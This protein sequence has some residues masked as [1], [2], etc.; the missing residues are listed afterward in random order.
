MATISKPTKEQWDDVK[1][2]LRLPYSNVYFLIDGYKVAASV[3][4]HKMRLV[5]T[6]YV[7]GY[8]RGNDLWHG[9]EN[10]I[11]QMPEIARRFY[12]LRRKAM[13]SAKQVRADERI[14]GKRDCKKR[15]IYDKYLFVSPHFSTAGAFIAHIKK[16]NQSIE[17]IDYE[18][19]KKAM[20]PLQR[21]AAPEVASV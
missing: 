21:D 9:Q 1:L 6:V 11:D 5:I 4:Q 10:E 2:N 7:N 15:G 14:F 18:A 16:H 19:Y 3:Q 8:I 13:Y 17:I 20:E 12:A